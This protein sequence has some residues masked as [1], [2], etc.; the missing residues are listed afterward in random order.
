M[1]EGKEEKIKVYFDLIGNPRATRGNGWVALVVGDNIQF[2][3][4]SIPE[5]SKNTLVGGTY[6]LPRG[7]YVIVKYDK[8]SHKNSR[9]YYVLYYVTG[10]QEEVKEVA[11]I[12]VINGNLSFKP[13][14]LEDIYIT[15]PSDAKSKIIYA[16]IQYAKTYIA[17]T[18][19]LTP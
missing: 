17:T 19:L 8:S 6:L 7:A 15:A 16:L 9:Q 2:L 10:G 14:G 12:D 3:R 18:Q 13:A 4:A 11:S 5:F 1:E